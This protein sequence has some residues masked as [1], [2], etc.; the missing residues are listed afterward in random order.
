[1]SKD[2]SEPSASSELAAEIRHELR[3]ILRQRDDLRRPLNKFE[4]VKDPTKGQPPHY[5]VF[6]L[7]PHRS[8]VGLRTQFNRLTLPDE[9]IID[10]V[11]GFAQSVWH[12]KDRLKLWIASRKM[13]LD[14]E[15]FAGSNPDLLIVADL[16]NSKKHGPLRRPRSCHTPCLGVLTSDE[17]E[18][19]TDGTGIVSFDTSRSGVAEL[20]YDSARAEK[21]L[22][23]TNRVP[24]PFTVEILVGDPQTSLGNAVEFIFLAFRGWLP[25]IEESSV[26][27]SDD[28]QTQELVNELG[29][30]CR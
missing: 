17:H 6:H 3:S 1:M 10:A 25:L 2:E 16:A 18:N 13:D 12:L 24:I 30:R 29:L 20:F 26:L 9:R 8:I 21:E 7:G 11:Y 22:L 23:V 19:P 4:P 28:R 5:V 27:D 15:A 14:V